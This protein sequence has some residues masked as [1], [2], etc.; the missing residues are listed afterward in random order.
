M[1]PG[2][3]SRSCSPG[4]SR[5]CSDELRQHGRLYNTTGGNVRAASLPFHNVRPAAAAPDVG[6]FS[7]GIAFSWVSR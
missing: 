3:A 5:T 2:E 1:C 7:D 6:V 4:C